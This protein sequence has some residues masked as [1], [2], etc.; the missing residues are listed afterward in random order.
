MIFKIR[1]LLNIIIPGDIVTYKNYENVLFVVFSNNMHT[2]VYENSTKKERKIQVFYRDEKH[3]N[4]W[5]QSDALFSPE[6]FKII[7]NCNIHCL[8][9][10]EVINKMKIELKRKVEK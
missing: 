1:Q 5:T 8:H 9:D 3:I 2:L 10:F 6:S 7:G 4:C